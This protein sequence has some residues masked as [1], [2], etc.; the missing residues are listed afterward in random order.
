MR[1]SPFRDE[2]SRIEADLLAGKPLDPELLS[3]LPLEILG[4]VYLGLRPG[5]PSLMAAL[6]SMAPAQVQRDWT[7]ADGPTLMVQSCAFVDSLAR[8]LPR[9]A[10]R[11]L[12]GAS[13]LDFGCGWGRLLRLLLRYTPADRIWGLDPWDRSI[14]LCR[15][16][17]IPV[18]LAVSD[19]VPKTLPV[20]DTHFDL[21]FAFS[22]FTHLS[23]KCALQVMKT[24]RAYLKEDGLLAITVRP[25]E[26][27]RR[28]TPFPS[29]LTAEAV[30]AAHRD[31]GFA[32]I[33]H[34]REPIDGDVT[35]GDATYSLEYVG[36]TWRDWSIVGT[37]SNAV[38]PLQTI[39]FLRPAS[40]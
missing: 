8:A 27:W 37:E 6:P 2:L 3:R 36:R 18:N 26:Y 32:Y 19:Y 31:A 1:A 10:G 33:P 13:V 39:I 15:A 28:H 11:P 23:P 34:H 40:V 12:V 25:E 7:G 9:Y 29:G 22:V 5:C 21:I 4:E 35:Y 16:H 17:R 38:D 20:G 24:L 14:D 30:L